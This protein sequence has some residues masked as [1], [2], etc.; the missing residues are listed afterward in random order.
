[1]HEPDPVTQTALAAWRQLKAAHDA[2]DFGGYLAMLTDDYTFSMPVGEFRGQH[3]GRD[4]AAECYRQIAAS[5]P[6][7]R[8]HDPLRVTRQGN[9]VV[10]EFEDEGTIQGR[11]Y[12]NRIASSF[13][14]R[15]DRICGYREYFGDIDP[16]MMSFMA[17]A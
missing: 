16:V 13:D 15:G 8:F 10:V 6:K 17:G 12:R 2:G 5:E 1:M 9:T 14:V 11:P 3:V 4:R 7:L